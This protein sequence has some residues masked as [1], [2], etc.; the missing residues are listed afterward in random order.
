MI[1]LFVT[2]FKEERII[3]GNQFLAKFFIPRAKT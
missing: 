2:F 1:P 3:G